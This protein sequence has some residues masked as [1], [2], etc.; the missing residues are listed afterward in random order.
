MAVDAPG[1]TVKEYT[2]VSKPLHTSKTI[3]LPLFLKDLL[4]YLAGL[5]TFH[6]QYSRIWK[7]LVKF[8]VVS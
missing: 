5:E 6:T 2:E 8:I 7:P 4:C 3:C 1:S